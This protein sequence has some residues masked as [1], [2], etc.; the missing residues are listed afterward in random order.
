MNMI[1]LLAN[2]YN[3]VTAV[4]FAAVFVSLTA[5]MA[6]ALLATKLK[7][8]WWP[9]KR[10]VAPVKI[11]PNPLPVEITKTLATKDD[12]EKLEKSINEVEADVEALDVKGDKKREE[13]RRE[14]KEDTERVHKRIGAISIKLATLGGTLNQVA[15]NVTSLVNKEIEK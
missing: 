15:G 14:F 3:D 5:L 8:A 12:V 2:N 4:Q 9:R 10:E 6:A 1:N 11:S 7:D 13:L